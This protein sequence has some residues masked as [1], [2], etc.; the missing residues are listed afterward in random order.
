MIVIACGDRHWAEDYRFGRM[1]K[2]DRGRDEYALLFN[3]LSDFHALRGID[4]LYEGE[5]R[6]ADQ[7][8]AS[9][10]Y[11][12]R[13]PVVPTRAKWTEHGECR[14][15]AGEPRCKAAG[16]R[17]N[18]E[19][20]AK[21]LAASDQTAARIVVLAFHRSF[22]ESKGTKDMVEIARRAG[23]EAHIFPGHGAGM[24]FQQT[25]WP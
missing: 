4:V 19:Q 10:A 9:W 11:G 16:P 17:R 2:H 12:Q 24:D 6:G 5:Q 22:Q 14:C 23:V 13:I 8:A 3:V 1:P 15:A 7:L 18:R 25:V 20:L 21:A